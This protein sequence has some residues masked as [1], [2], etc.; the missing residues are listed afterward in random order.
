[1]LIF[2]C[3]AIRASVHTL[4]PLSLLTLNLQVSLKLF[5][6]SGLPQNESK[7]LDNAR[8]ELRATE[9]IHLKVRPQIKGETYM[10]A[11]NTRMLLTIA[12][13]LGAASV[14]T[15]AE[16]VAFLR[17]SI[18]FDFTVANQA[19]PAGNYTISGSVVY[20]QSVIW[21]QSWDGKHNA[22]VS[23][24]PIYALDRSAGT[25][26]IFQHS[27]GEYFLSQLWTQGSSSGREVQLSERAKELVR[28]GSSGNA[29]TIAADASFSH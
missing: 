17:V 3:P 11:K 2:E 1:M 6:S 28:N 20:S 9:I 29:V 24:H 12:L 27:G 19:L 21:L 10:I 14:Y 25:Q 18:P 4:Q 15:Q 7:R 16:N 8:S 26:L 22:V 23:I 13:L 5:G